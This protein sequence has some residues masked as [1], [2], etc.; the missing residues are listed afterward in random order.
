MTMI[1]LEKETALAIANAA[2]SPAPQLSP[3]SKKIL[4]DAVAPANPRQPVTPRWLKISTAV[5]YSAIGRSTLYEL[6]NAGKIRSHRIGGA[7]V[8]DRESLDAFISSQPAVAV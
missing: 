1:K 8:I 4:T 7:R 5:A 2:A 3:Q 6:M